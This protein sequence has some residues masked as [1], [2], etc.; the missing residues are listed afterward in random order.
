MKT[1]STSLAVH[2]LG[3]RTKWI[4][5]EWNAHNN[6]TL[7]KDLTKKIKRSSTNLRLWQVQS[8]QISISSHKSTSGASSIRLSSIEPSFCGSSL[9]TQHYAWC[10]LASGTRL[11]CWTRGM[12]SW[13]VLKQSCMQHGYFIALLTSKSLRHIA[14][15]HIHQQDYSYTWWL[16]FLSCQQLSSSS[17]SPRSSFCSAHA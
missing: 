2:L 14:M 9:S 6:L 17:V 7:G 8:L 4:S 11:I 1:I 12:C 13:S 3:S 15:S 10:A 16:S 5:E